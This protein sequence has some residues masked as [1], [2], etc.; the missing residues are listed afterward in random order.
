MSV[1]V[2]IY[3]RQMNEQKEKEV[4]DF[5]LKKYNI[6]GNYIGGAYP[7]WELSGEKE[8]VVKAIEDNWLLHGFIVPEE[9]MDKE[10]MKVLGFEMSD[11]G[12]IDNEN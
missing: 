9:V 2:L 7:A 8:D 12:K 4:K 11:E 6:N 3:S 5:L 1:T 10:T